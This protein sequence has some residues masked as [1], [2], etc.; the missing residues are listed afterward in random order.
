MDTFRDYKYLNPEI[1]KRLIFLMNATPNKIDDYI[2]EIQTYEVLAKEK[3]GYMYRT[4]TT[5]FNW[6]DA[7]R[8]MKIK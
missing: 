8:P 7:P 4:R 3:Y 1:T 5:G 2:S 6:E